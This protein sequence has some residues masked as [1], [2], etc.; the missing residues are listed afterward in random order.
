M[1]ASYEPARS[2]AYSDDLRWRMVYQRMALG[3]TFD[4]I[5]KNPGVDKSTAQSTVT[6]HTGSVH[7][8]PYP[9]E[10]A[11]R[12]LCPEDDQLSKITTDCGL[13]SL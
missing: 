1:K 10:K 11:S 12:H 2:S 5:S 4:Q 7:K 6:I 3:L 9:K 8:R 13:I